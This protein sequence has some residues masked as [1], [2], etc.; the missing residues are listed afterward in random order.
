MSL[1]DEVL[2]LVAKARL[3]GTD[4]VAVEVKKAAGG[5]PKTL[6]E[7]VSAFANGGG[8]IIVLGLDEKH[9]FE[10]VNVDSKALANA[11]ATACSDQVEPAVRAQIEIV[12]VD[13]KSVVAA[14]IPPID[15]RIRPC[16]VKTQ[17]IERG[18]YIRS[19]DGDR[20]L[21]SY[22]IHLMV[23]GRGQPHD[24]AVVVPGAT[25]ADLDQVGVQRLVE[26]YRNR[27]G[28]VFAKAE[29]IDVLRMAGVCPR[30]ESG[31]QVSLAGLLALGIYP[32]QFS[33]QLNVTFVSYPTVDGRP[34]ADGTRFLENVPLDGSIPQLVAGLVAV[35]QRNMTRHSVVHGIGREDVWEYPVEAIRE[36]IVNALM[37]RDYHPLAQGTQ[38]RV[39]MYPDRLLFINPGGLYGA[40]NPTELLQGTVSS[41]RNAVLA[42]LLE[43]VEL[44]NT[45][46]T[47][48]ENRGSGIRTIA[49]ELAAS[50][51]PLPFFK[52][53]SGM[54]IAELRNT[55]I[56]PPSSTNHPREEITH[57]TTENPT[58]IILAA[59]A[60]APKTTTEL[61]ELTGLTRSGVLRHLRTLETNGIIIPTTSRR[62]S[63]TLKW[64][65]NSTILESHSG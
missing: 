20:H 36:L 44:P 58:E 9:G 22:E 7:S 17:G 46:R 29:V 47:I 1:Q 39:E 57:T 65:S 49:T 38:V 12:Q 18:S 64:A 3:V 25:L 34:M 2:A 60:N 50:G 55:V 4:T 43:D 51:L 37:H 53:A 26:R 13:G 27:R 52:V 40:A 31:D 24:D 56:Q 28:P 10:P 16:Y 41:S 33:P 8:G 21:T 48:C 45:N 32:Q 62:R 59:L 42:R 15:S 30:G 61:M 23:T 19:H 54:F 35:V 11:M 63:P 14:A 5:A 6:A